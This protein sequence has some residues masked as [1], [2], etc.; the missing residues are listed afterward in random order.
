LKFSSFITILVLLLV[1]N[2][3]IAQD[4]T[5]IIDSIGF[6]GNKRTKLD[7][8]NELVL[9]VDGAEYSESVFDSLLTES[10]HRLN[11]SSLFKTVHTTADTV[12]DSGKKI[13][14]VV[15]VLDERWYT[16]PFPIFRL[17]DPNFNLWWRDKDFN[18][19]SYGG[20]T[21]LENIN[22]RGDQLFVKLVSGFRKE[23]RVSYKKFVRKRWGFSYG[24]SYIQYPTLEID[25]VNGER[26]FKKRTPAIIKER[27]G[28]SLSTAKQI[29]AHQSVGFYIDVYQSVALDSL[30][31]YNDRY[32]GESGR[33]RLITTYFSAGYSSDSRDNVA[34]PHKGQYFSISA[35]VPVLG[36]DEVLFMSAIDFRRYKEIDRHL[37]AVQLQGQLVLNV[38][39][40]TAFEFL[41][42]NRLTKVP[43]IFDLYVPNTINWLQSR[44]QYFFLLIKGKTIKTDFIPVKQF[45]HPFVS[46]A[47]GPF[48]DQAYLHSYSDNGS[49]YNSWL[50]ST[51]VSV[52]LASY[53]D[54]V[55]R[56]DAGYN[57]LG[58]FGV[59]LHFTKAL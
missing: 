25:N 36:K 27:V 24:A 47:V 59:F 31:D 33:S 56:F 11:R 26:I 46:L 37:L 34:F 39:D 22:G 15:F 12:L 3:A 21:R 9:L 42:S 13:V 18:R 40:Q 20:A 48:I 35:R 2:L 38:N 50:V 51:G 7:F 32:F 8:L 55:M 49:L 57:S 30:L 23:F 43:R 53:Y 4:G 58:D 28:L 17:T 16:W 6:E 29:D 41:T 45:K 44:S 10:E 5:V 54:K 52:Q 19:I 14:K 1:A